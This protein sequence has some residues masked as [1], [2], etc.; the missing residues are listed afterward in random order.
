MNS[1]LIHPKE[2]VYF[3]ICVAV[4][5][6]IYL[7]LL[8]SIIGIFYALI[9]ILLSLFFQGIMLG[10]IRSNGVK[11]SNHQFPHIK[12]KVEDLC[13]KMN[14]LQVPDVYVLESGGILNAFATRFFGRNFIILYSDIFELIEQDGE[15]ELTFIIAHEL[16]HLQ[17][18]HIS[19]QLLILPATW[20]PFLG[21]AYSRTCEYSCD[22]IATYYTGNT[23]VAMK[24]LT[25][26][27][28]GKVL[29]KKVNR[30][31]YL[32]QS[33]LEQGF[34]V[35]LSQLI[36]SHPPLP[37][38]ILELEHIEKFPQFYGLT[39]SEKKNTMMV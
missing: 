5:A 17:R 27:A 18:K 33:S 6:L 16:A 38:R 36:S 3:S 30:T 35:W 1:R 23:E 10:N 15:E 37:K 29:F 2:Q 25:L 14:I 12:E 20:V 8:F 4:S 22:R 21:N 34:F 24:G 19:K 9:G 26:M 39:S 28:I 31:D 7:V 32:L 11:L 13:V